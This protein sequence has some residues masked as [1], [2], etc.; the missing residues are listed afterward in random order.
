MQDDL[1]EKIQA[2]QNKFEALAARIPGYAGYKAREQRREADKLL[3][4]YVARQYEEQ[5]KRLQ[6]IQ[7]RLA[8]TGQLHSL[9]ALERAV[10]R[11]QLLIDRIKTASY[12]YAGLFDALKVDETALDRLYAFDQAMLDGVQR[13]ADHLN[14]LAQAIDAGE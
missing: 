2:A 3:R 4:L 13:L 1:T 6:D 7:G 12:G 10:M 9:F 14:A 11:L 5:M 8:D